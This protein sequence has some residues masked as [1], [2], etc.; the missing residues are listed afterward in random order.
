MLSINT[1]ALDASHTMEEIVGVN[2]HA[3]AFGD[4]C[5]FAGYIAVSQQSDA[6]AF[7]FTTNFSVKTMSNVK[8]QISKNKFGNGIGILAR[9]VHHHNVVSCGS[10]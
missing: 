10:G 2:I 1:I 7:E 6:F 3:E 9:G 8:E 4:A 5:H